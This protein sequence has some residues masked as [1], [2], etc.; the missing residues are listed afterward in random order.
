[1]TPLLPSGGT[2]LCNSKITLRVSLLVLYRARMSYAAQRSDNGT[3]DNAEVGV[4]D[5]PG[6]K[7]SH[8]FHLSNVGGS[9][10][11]H[12]PTPYSK[13][14]GGGNKP[15]I[16]ASSSHYRSE[17]LSIPLSPTFYIHPP[18]R[19]AR[20]WHCSALDLITFGGKHKTHCRLFSCCFNFRVLGSRKS[21]LS[22]MMDGTISGDRSP[23]ETKTK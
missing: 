11:R 18:N 15:I 13:R 9:E 14:R 12:K 7:A 22:S 2:V 6:S 16:I 4:G 21:A 1:M 20:T 5:C 3:G 19:P 23:K 8:G 17:S 10:D